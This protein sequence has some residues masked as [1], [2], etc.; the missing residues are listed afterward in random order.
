[1]CQPV[2]RPW[3]VCVDVEP[4]NGSAVAPGGCAHNA[5]VSRGPHARSGA[6]EGWSARLSEGRVTTERIAD[7]GRGIGGRRLTIRGTAPLSNVPACGGALPGSSRSLC[8]PI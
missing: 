7:D 3:V 5:D 6:D 8:F 2:A 4:D 1:M